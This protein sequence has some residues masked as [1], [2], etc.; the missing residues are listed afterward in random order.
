MVTNFVAHF[1]FTINIILTKSHRQINYE[2]FL[3]LLN[4]QNYF[5]YHCM[6]TMQLYQ[7][8]I[9]YYYIRLISN[10]SPV[11]VTL[12]YNCSNE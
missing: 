7:L 5:T 9:R 10:D 1:N 6:I 4:T 12:T 11:N 2:E 3:R 8:S